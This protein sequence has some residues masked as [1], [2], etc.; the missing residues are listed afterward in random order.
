M[1]GSA[2]RLNENISPR[3]ASLF[4]YLTWR[5]NLRCSHCWVDAGEGGN[6]ECEMD[7]IDSFL[8][9]ALLNPISF[10]KFSGGEPTLCWDKLV[11]IVEKTKGL[12]ITYALET[13]G[14]FL[15]EEKVNYLKTNKITIHMSLNGTSP[16]RQDDFSGVEGSFSHALESLEIMKKLNYLPDEIVTCVDLVTMHELRD[17]ID[18]F[19]DLG[20]KRVKVNPIMPQGRGENSA[21]DGLGLSPKD[22]LS[23]VRIVEEIRQTASIRVFLDEPMCTRS[24]ADIHKHTGLSSCGLAS[25]LSFLPNASLSL[26]G[27]GN[28]DE[29]V[30]VAHWDNQSSLSDI[31]ANNDLLKQIRCTGAKTLAEPCSDCIHL[32]VCQGSCRVSSYHRYGRWDMPMPLCRDLYEI[33]LFPSSRLTS[34]SSKV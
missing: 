3:L 33:G 6:D 8:E 18:F 2:D 7:L 29:S 23:L 27:Y 24:F 15:S 1:N 4:F 10:I 30:I 22:H 13:N 17:R 25:I 21:R 28:I 20:V 12:G 14:L 26:C 19:A 9:Q 31:W 16:L 32:D 34:R 11:H 5:C